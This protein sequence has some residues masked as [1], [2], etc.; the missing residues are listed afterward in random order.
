MKSSIFLGV[1]FERA[2]VEGGFCHEHLQY[3]H[4]GRY[5]IGINGYVYDHESLEVSRRP[6][7]FSFMAGD[8]LEFLYQPWRLT[9]SKNGGRIWEFQLSRPTEGDCYRPCV[10]LLNTGDVAQMVQNRV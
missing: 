10:H 4:H 2:A 5:V 8:Q 3:N 6:Q 7:E 9:I 1:C